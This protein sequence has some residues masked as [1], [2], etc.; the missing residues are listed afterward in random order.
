[1]RSTLR[2]DRNNTLRNRALAIGLVAVMGLFATKTQGQ[3]ITKEQKDAIKAAKITM[4]LVNSGKVSQEEAKAFVLTPG[5]LDKYKDSKIDSLYSELCKKDP[6]LKDFDNQLKKSVA[7]KTRA[8]TIQ[9][10]TLVGKSQEY[11]DRYN[12]YEDT[13]NQYYRSRN[14]NV[15]DSNIGLTASSDARRAMLYEDREEGKNFMDDELENIYG[16]NAKEL[17]V[18]FKEISKE[19]AKKRDRISKQFGPRG[20]NKTSR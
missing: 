14:K 11:I 8:T 15:P 12:D 18:L 17:R 7:T 2:K 1:M 16:K 6:N 19:N 20:Y 3:E 5:V 4:I 10:F 9:N 13:F